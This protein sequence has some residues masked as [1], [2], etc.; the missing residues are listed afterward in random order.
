MSIDG[1]LDAEEVAEEDPQKTG[2]YSGI[3]S[4]K[5]GQARL[6]RS[7]STAQR[8]QRVQRRGRGKGGRGIK[9]G[10]RPA[11]EPNGEFIAL[12]KEAV[13]VFID[14]QD[15]DRALD[16][17]QRAIALNPEVYAAHALLSEIYVAKGENEKAVAA[18]FS[19]AHAAPR[20][21]NVWHQVADACLQRSTLDRTQALEQA[22]YCFARL[23]DIDHKDYDSRFQRAAINRELGNHTKAL[24]EFEKI[25]AEMPHNSSI[26]S[27]IAEI[28]IDINQIERAKELY[29]ESIAYHERTGM[30][31]EDAFSWSDINIYA[32][33]FRVQEQ[34]DEGIATLKSLSRWLLGR[35]TETFWDDFT[36]DD[37]EWDADD[38][39]RR[40]GVLDYEP[41]RYP[42]EAYGDGLPLELR[43]KLGVF[44]LSQA[45][46]HRSEA[47]GHFEWLDPEEAGAG[48]KV[49]DY[50]DL[51]REAAMALR[52]V[53][54]YSEA[55]RYFEPLKHVQAYSDA[56]FWLAMASSSYICDR[57][58]QAVEC[59]EAAKAAD[60]NGAEARTQLAKIYKDMGDRTKALA[61]AHEALDIGRRAVIV[62]PLRRRYE[63][64]EQREAREA[65][66]QALKEANKLPIP[67]GEPSVTKRLAYDFNKAHSEFQL[68]GIPQSLSI[69]DATLRER[70]YRRYKRSKG[71]ILSI[72]EA[73]MRRT[74]NI[75]SLY[76]TLQNLTKS[77][78]DGDVI[79]RNTWLD[80]AGELIADFRSNRVFYPYERHIK[81]K[82]YDREARAETF[83]KKW[84]K[85]HAAARERESSQTTLGDDTDITFPSTDSNVPVHYRGIH[86]NTWL[87]VFLEQ[88]LI[89]AKLGED[90]K[91]KAYKTLTASLDCTIWYH[92]PESMLQIHVCYFTCALALNDAQTMTNVVAR[93]FM[94]QYQF[95]TDTYR[96]FAALNLLYVNPNVVGGKDMQMQR[97][98]F[99][100]GASQKFLFRQVKALDAL[101]PP[102][103]GVGTEDGP[104]PEWMREDARA[105][106]NEEVDKDARAP[107]FPIA[108]AG[109]IVKPR[110]MD[111]VLLTIY[112]HILYAGNSYPNALRYFYRAYTLD[113]KNCMVLLSIALSYCHQMF[114][115]QNENRHMYVLQGLAFLQEY[116][117]CRLA[118][119]RMMGSEELARQEVEFNRARVWHMIGLSGLAVEAYGKVLNGATTVGSTANVR[120][121]VKGEG[122]SFSLEAAYAMQNLYALGGDAATARQITDKWLVVE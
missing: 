86:F 61:N 94:R 46:E 25:L 102:D 87:D 2:P 52:E 34:Y 78:R 79:A 68:N 13:N 72:E 99:R 117:D 1:D 66:E 27:Q 10:P 36:E 111:I 49:F 80:C 114:K 58:E 69:R 105:I 6:T 17:I 33:L 70:P 73:E 55:L 30:I 29:E 110:E 108:D 44:R 14:D 75:Q 109:S 96:L 76:M 101:L 19:G 23:I 119:G 77:M 54:E 37:R 5:S 93:W 116:A 64:R 60:A 85:E 82:G 47:F 63:R 31:G 71:Q 53:K 120:D 112:G 106:D 9:R 103:Y 11:V 98:P 92:Q 3:R 42:L 22:A 21:P 43:V 50:S 51:Y 91:D 95:C 84:R 97:A 39:P 18:L 15:H 41:G 16:I 113:P 48:S 32:E 62:H 90:H 65:A 45:R 4:R 118:E 107:A 115:R 121:G 7:T 59:Y 8:G 12:Q 20:D 104:V 83:Q 74:D 24:N 88:A 100:Q 38:D 26:L 56:T 57:K 89:L 40:D 35:K 81:F 122:E 28:C 67:E